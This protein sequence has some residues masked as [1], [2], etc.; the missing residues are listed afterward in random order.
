MISAP[1]KDCAERHVLC[2][3]TCDAYISY[4][5][6]LELLRTEDRR[7]REIESTTYILKR[8]R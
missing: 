1:C 2:H 3:S 7:R 5:K 4:K 6:Q 8:K